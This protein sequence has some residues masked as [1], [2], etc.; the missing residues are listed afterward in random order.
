LGVLDGVPSIC[1]RAFCPSQFFLSQEIHPTRSHARTGVF[2]NLRAGTRQ[3]H[4]DLGRTGNGRLLTE[5]AFK[6][7]SDLLN[8]LRCKFD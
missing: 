5:L 2:E 1:Y 3:H 7:A 8:V 4:Y 6:H